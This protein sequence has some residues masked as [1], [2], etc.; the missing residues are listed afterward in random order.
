VLS[1]CKQ[2][3][4]DR[5]VAP[6][7]LSRCL[8]ESLRSQE[9][10][11]TNSNIPSPWI[12]TEATVIIDLVLRF[13]KRIKKRTRK[14]LDIGIIHKVKVARKAGKAAVPPRPTPERRLAAGVSAS[15]STAPV[16]SEASAPAE[17]A[18]ASLPFKSRWKMMQGRMAPLSTAHF[19]S[20]DAS[21][22]TTPSAATPPGSTLS[23][24][25]PAGALAPHGKGKAPASSPP[26]PLSDDIDQ[27]AEGE[28]DDDLS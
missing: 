26:S 7:T 22:Q 3:D 20:P 15:A 12:L 23:S 24:Y 18:S 28:P 2:Y 19:D 17:D 5:L 6:P 13:R 14:G 16:P 21:T 4:S 27:D 25:D 10:G 9:E 11:Y 8:G 1:D